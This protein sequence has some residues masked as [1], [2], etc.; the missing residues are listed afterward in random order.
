MA[1]KNWFSAHDIAKLDDQY[2][3][4][5]KFAQVMEIFVTGTSKGEVKLWS[6]GGE[7]Q[8]LGILNSSHHPWNNT[9]VMRV[10]EDVHRKKR[11]LELQEQAEKIVAIK[12]RKNREM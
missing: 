6:S 10:I 11:N 8:L 12:R 1:A 7:C 9:S 4:S 3:V 2:V 5:V